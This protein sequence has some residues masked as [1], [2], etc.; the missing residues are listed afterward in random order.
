MPQLP[1]ETER[2]I[3][4]EYRESDT[5]DVH[6]YAKDPEVVR[7]MPWGPNT[8]VDSREFHK[9]IAAEQAADPRVSWELAIE[10]KAEGRVIGGCGV[11]IQNA[12]NRE[13][14]MGYVLNRA[15][16]GQGIITEAARAML[17]FGFNQLGMH[18]IWATCH[19]DNIGSIRV[20]E[21]I[22]MRREG[23]LRENIWI[24]DRWRDSLLYAILDD[25][26]RAASRR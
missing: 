10:L 24:R 21:K 5:A 22:G 23:Y 19:P 18:R 12:E 9:R 15:Y 14:D 20:L 1:L 2:L 16:W 6:E 7:H 4:R 8:E 26:W 3:L 11:R 17:A 13:A 25:E